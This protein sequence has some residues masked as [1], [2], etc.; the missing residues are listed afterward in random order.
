MD[1]RPDPE[2]GYPSDYDYD[3]FGDY[4]NDEYNDD[5]YDDMD[6]DFDSGMTSAGHGMD[7][8]YGYYGG[9]DEY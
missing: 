1:N 3:E 4:D 7:E 6:G 2:D 5:Y 9:E 8:D